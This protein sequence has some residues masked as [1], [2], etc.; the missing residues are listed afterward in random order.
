MFMLVVYTIIYIYNVH[1]YRP[2]GF[3]IFHWSTKEVGMGWTKVDT[4][5]LWLNVLAKGAYLI[6]G[7]VRPQWTHPLLTILYINSE[8]NIL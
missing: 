7:S 5:C 4:E 6:L 2:H 3:Y 8:F 1:S